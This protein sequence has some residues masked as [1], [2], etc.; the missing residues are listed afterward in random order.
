[1]A[2]VIRRVEAAFR[3]QKEAPYGEKGKHLVL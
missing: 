1:M 3:P 2:Q